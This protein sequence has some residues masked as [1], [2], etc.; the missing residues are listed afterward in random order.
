ML[1]RISISLLNTNVLGNSGVLSAEH[2]T[3]T[4]WMQVQLTMKNELHSDK[5]SINGTLQFSI[6]QALLISKNSFYHTP[7]KYVIH[8]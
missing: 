8:R 3:E 2:A 6:L 5:L 7:P 4:H 1:L